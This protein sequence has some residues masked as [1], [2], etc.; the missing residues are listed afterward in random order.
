MKIVNKIIV[1]G[2][3]TAGCISALILKTQ[4]PQMNISIIESKNVGIIGVGESS[5][6]HWSNFCQFVG[7][8]AL[9]AIIH[10]NATFK[11]GV[12]FENWSDKDFIHNISPPYAKTYGS[13]YG[14]Y[15]HLIS[16][17]QNITDPYS[18]ANELSTNG[19]NHTNDSPYFQFHFDTFALNSYLHEICKSKEIDIIY[20]D[21]VG[22]HLKEESGD[23]R[24]VFSDDFE[25]DADFFIDCSGFSRLL[26]NQVYQIP[27]ISYSEFL[28]LNS[29]VAF[30][31]DEMEEYNKYTK[32]TARNAGWSWTIPTQTRTGNGYV[33]CDEFIDKDEA[34]KEMEEAYGQSLDIA[35]EFKFDPGRLEKAWH[36]NCYAVGLSQSFVEPLEATSIGS[37]IQ[38]MF[39]FIHF[40]P[41][42][43]YN[44]CND[45][46]NDIFDNIVDY[47]QAHYLVKREDTP[48][49]KQV[50]YNLKL[51][52]KLES[53]LEKWKYR[54]PLSTDVHCQWGMFESSNYIPILYGLGWFDVDKIRHEYEEYHSSSLDDII[55]SE[56][57][58]NNRPSFSISHKKFIKEVLRAGYTQDSTK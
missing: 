16:N 21:L 6:E 58:N 47:V 20:D 29:A 31:T 41:S 11:S 5:T 9:S 51:T 32:S 10:C 27:W 22:V 34:H 23:I 54:L 17:N 8:D 24:A 35:R 46:V 48:F 43:D 28:P 44:T 52:P 12:Y 36:K 55:K 18:V 33:Y 30:A 57:N 39:T 45:I 53:Y 7:I 37:V 15:A 19:F 13:Y 2:G 42:F 40:L 1:V 56:L 3:G 4:F 26:L 38:Q 49:W 25:Y 14:V 50:K